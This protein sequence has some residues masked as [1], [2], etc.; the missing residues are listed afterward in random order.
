MYLLLN[1][2][3]SAFTVATIQSPVP[4]TVPAANGGTVSS[5]GYIVL[6]TDETMFLVLLVTITGIVMLVAVIGYVTYR[7]RWLRTV[8]L[9]VAGFLLWVFAATAVLTYAFTPRTASVAHGEHI[10]HLARSL[11]ST[12]Y[13]CLDETGICGGDEYRLFECNRLALKCQPVGDVFRATA[14][15]LEIKGYLDA[16]SVLR[17]VRYNGRGDFVDVVF[18]VP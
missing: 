12:R 1:L 10:Y 4:G 15:R 11:F 3:V 8:A 9:F 7:R 13:A 17:V 5:T 18:E 14:S 16:P 2:L 6:S